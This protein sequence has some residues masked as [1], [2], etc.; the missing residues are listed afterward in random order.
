[1]SPSTHVHAFVAGAYPLQSCQVAGCGHDRSH[2]VHLQAM[3]LAKAVTC[4]T[5]H[6]YY[7]ESGVITPCPFCLL[8]QA[9]ETHTR[10]S[11]IKATLR[12]LCNG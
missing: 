10:L 4:E 11:R 8:R 1:M 7:Q 2:E 9:T 5:G 12:E 6:R 3:R